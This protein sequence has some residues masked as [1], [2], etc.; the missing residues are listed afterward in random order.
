MFMLLCQYFEKLSTSYLNRPKKEIKARI[1]GLFKR[2]IIYSTFLHMDHIRPL[3]LRKS[4]E[5]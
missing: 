3:E 5:P 1:F 2:K 4:L